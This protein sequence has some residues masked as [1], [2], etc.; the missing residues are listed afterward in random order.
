MKQRVWII[1]FILAGI[2][3]GVGLFMVFSEDVVYLMTGAIL[4]VFALFRVVPLL[5]TLKHEVSRTIHLIEVLV[6]AILGGVLI[7][8]SLQLGSDGGNTNLW[9]MIYRYGLGFVFYARGVIYFISTVFFQEKTKILE[10]IMHVVSI[11]I[12]TAIVFNSQFNASF[13]GIFFLI[14]SIIGAAIL[15]VDGYGGYKKYRLA[16][17]NDEKQLENQ[18]KKEKTL[19]LEDPQEERTY[20]N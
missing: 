14:M 19:P 5:K 8:A 11:S 13:I 7:F 17:K 10:F 9:E 15:T 3:L 18:P 20:I 1:K 4:V 6:T 16:F 12:G 2:L